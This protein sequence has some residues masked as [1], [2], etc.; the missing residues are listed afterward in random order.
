MHHS[1]SRCDALQCF[2]RQ[3]GVCSLG[4]AHRTPLPRWNWPAPV[5]VAAIQTKMHC[6]RLRHSLL[7]SQHRRGNMGNH[8]L[9]QNMRNYEGYFKQLAI[10]TLKNAVQDVKDQITKH[11]NYLP[12]W[13]GGCNNEGCLVASSVRSACHTTR[14]GHKLLCCK[15][16]FL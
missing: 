1:P 6:Q 15:I 16:K 3:C 2:C 4:A 11:R 10:N 13:D 8:E 12:G 9:K 5:W 7:H 14:L